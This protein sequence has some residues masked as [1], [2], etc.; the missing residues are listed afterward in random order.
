[1]EIGDSFAV[2]YTT[3]QVG[4]IIGGLNRQ[5]APKHLVQRSVEENGKK[6]LRFW[7]VR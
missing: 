2:E 7:R 5:I 1:M 4:G 6:M 3:K